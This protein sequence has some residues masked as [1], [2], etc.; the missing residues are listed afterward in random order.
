[1]GDIYQI[2]GRGESEE[3]FS[4]WENGRGRGTNN[5]VV[6]LEIMLEIYL[7]DTSSKLELKKTDAGGYAIQ[8]LSWIDTF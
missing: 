4:V 5:N 7:K 3:L 6:M 1:M 2:Y 8:E